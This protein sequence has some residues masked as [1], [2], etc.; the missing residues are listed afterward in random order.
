MTYQEGL[1]QIDQATRKITEANQQIVGP[2][3]D[4]RCLG[5]WIYTRKLIG[6]IHILS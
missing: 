3:S 5:G 4:C 6:L 2:I 1:N